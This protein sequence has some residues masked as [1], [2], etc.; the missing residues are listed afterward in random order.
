MDKKYFK[1]MTQQELDNDAFDIKDFL[2][3]KPNNKF[4]GDG[5]CANYYEDTNKISITKMNGDKLLVYSFDKKTSS[6]NVTNMYFFN[7][8]IHDA[9]LVYN[10]KLENNNFKIPLFNSKLEKVAEQRIYYDYKTSEYK[11]VFEN[12]TKNN[13]YYYNE[14]NTVNEVVFSEGVADA[15]C[16]RQFIENKN[17]GV[18]CAM[19]DSNM[20]NCFDTLIN[21]NKNIK[22]VYYLIDKDFNINENLNNLGLKTF[23]KIKQKYENSEFVILPILSN[24]ELINNDK[25][26]IKDFCDIYKNDRQQLEYIKKN[27]NDLKNGKIFTTKNNIDYLIECLNNNKNMTN[28]IIKVLIKSLQL[29]KITVDNKKTMVN[30]IQLKNENVYEFLSDLSKQIDFYD[31]DYNDIIA[32]TLQYIKNIKIN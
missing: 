12:S 24:N 14:I 3:S 5:F 6:N 21:L 16:F 27:I 31:F 17:I 22:I 1:Y 18:M 11:K 23:L 15:L 20:Q 26:V 30:N 28:E 8:N 7:K 2:I 4:Y 9:N 13:F 25:Y 19:T 32:K 10:I 29:Y